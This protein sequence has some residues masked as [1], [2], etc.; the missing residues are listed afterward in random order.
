MDMMQLA[1]GVLSLIITLLAH[2]AATLM[3]RASS[4]AKTMT[5]QTVQQPAAP[6]Q[7]AP[8][9]R[10]EYASLQSSALGKEL[11]YAVQFPPS[12]DRDSKRRYPVLYFLHGMF[13]SEQ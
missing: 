5:Q 12:Y 9:G 4:T 13:G 10:V 6:T 7:S 3:P 2:T 1:I 11:K 8:E